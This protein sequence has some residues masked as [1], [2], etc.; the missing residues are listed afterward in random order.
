MAITQRQFGV[1]T[2]DIDMVVHIV[3]K[4]IV[5]RGNSSVQPIKKTPIQKER[6]L[7]Y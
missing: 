3:K 7:Y 1:L 6:C 2:V 4:T 5:I